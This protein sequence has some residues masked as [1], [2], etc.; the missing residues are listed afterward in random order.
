M[1][2]RVRIRNPRTFFWGGSL[3]I[4][5]SVSDPYGPKFSFSKQNPLLATRLVGIPTLHQWQR[6]VLVCGKARLV[7]FAGLQTLQCCREHFFPPNHSNEHLL[8][9]MHSA[10][11]ASPVLETQPQ[12]ATVLCRHVGC[13]RASMHLLQSVLTY[14]QSVIALLRPLVLHVLVTL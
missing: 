14:K 8:Q 10:A 3:R 13:V 9:S 11:C 7:T 2:I 6:S 1:D 12:L 5:I 4:W